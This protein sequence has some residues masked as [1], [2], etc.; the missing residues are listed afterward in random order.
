MLVSGA[1]P[2]I[3]VTIVTMVVLFFVMAP[4][5][6]SL[7]HLMKISVNR[8]SGDVGER[9]GTDLRELKFYSII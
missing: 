3:I 6:A 2:V 9:G 8:K 5:A 1:G 4:A 7:H